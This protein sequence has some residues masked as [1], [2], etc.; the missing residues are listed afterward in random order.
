MVTTTIFRLGNPGIFSTK[1]YSNDLLS[2]CGRLF[3]YYS[4]QSLSIL[5]ALSPDLPIAQ[6]SLHFDAA[7][8]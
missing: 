4:R 6:G 2:L 5:D 8:N 3:S 7:R 1:V